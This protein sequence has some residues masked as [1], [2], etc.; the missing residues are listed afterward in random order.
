VQLTGGNLSEIREVLGTASRRG[1]LRDIGGGR[2]TIAARKITDYERS[3]LKVRF[4]DSMGRSRW[5]ARDESIRAFAEYLGYLRIVAAVERT[6][7]SLILSLIR[8]GQVEKKGQLIRRK[9]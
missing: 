4:L 5:R 8:T 1:V 3:F 6:A 9:S 7:E 2:I